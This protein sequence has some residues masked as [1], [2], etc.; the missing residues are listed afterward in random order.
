[1][2]ECDEQKY[3]VKAQSV[4]NAC[5]ENEHFYKVDYGIMLVS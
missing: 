3:N 4:D 1:M 2:L 5:V